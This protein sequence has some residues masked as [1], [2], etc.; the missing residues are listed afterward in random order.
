MAFA[1]RVGIRRAT[2]RVSGVCPPASGGFHTTIVAPGSGFS[3]GLTQLIASNQDNIVNAITLSEETE[4]IAPQITLGA[5]GTIFWD[6]VGGQH[7]ELSPGS[8]LTACLFVAGNVDVTAFYILYD[9]RAP[10]TKFAART[11]SFNNITV[12]RTPNRAGNQSEG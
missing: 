2:V 4:Q 11:N 12:T 1:K 7:L 8:G 10:V 6:D 5:S 9:R 3:V